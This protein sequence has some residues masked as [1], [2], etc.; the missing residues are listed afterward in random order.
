[1]TGG[2][3]RT[4][5]G[6]E[7]RVKALARDCLPVSDRRLS[8]H[9]QPQETVHGQ[10]HQDVHAEGNNV[11]EHEA[12]AADAGVWHQALEWRKHRSRERIDEALEAGRLARAKPFEDIERGDAAALHAMDFEVTPFFCPAC[13]ACYCGDHWL[14]HDVFD[15]DDG[16]HD[17]IRGTCPQGH[18]RMLED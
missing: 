14:R 8:L 9:E 1:M 2:V 4:L 3:R 11:G 10:V 13:E 16:W 17:S 15:P 7:P 12:E 18:E 6:R 5:L